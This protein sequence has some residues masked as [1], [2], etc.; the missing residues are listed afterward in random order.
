MTDEAF[1]VYEKLYDEL[2]QVLNKHTDKLSSEDD[3]VVRD[4]LQDEFR[5]WRLNK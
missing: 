5:F 4:R 3:A 2:H 1:A